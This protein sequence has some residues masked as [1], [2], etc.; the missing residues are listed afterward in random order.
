MTEDADI[1]AEA[2][3]RNKRLFK[4]LASAANAD[5]VAVVGPN[6]PG[7]ARSRGENLWTMSFTCEAWRVDGNKIQKRP[8]TVC[9]KVTG[10]ELEKLQESIQPYQVIRIKARVVI[11]SVFGSPQA[12]L[13]AFVAR[14]SS[15]AEL[16]HVA[17]ELQKPVTLEDS[18]LGTFTLDRRVDWFVGEVVWAGEPISL[19]LSA[20]ADV[21]EALKT[22]HALW[23][24]QKEW[25]RRVRSFAVEQLLP[26]KNDN[27][28]DEDE[29]ELTPD[30]FED[31]MTLESITV[32]ADGSF[33]FWHSDGDLF[34]GHS[35]QISGNLVDGPNHADI[36]G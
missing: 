23:R 31:R 13:E 33:D 28:L 18:L 20:S 12:L 15:D 21:Q 24:N 25:N 4:Q 7:A 9:R 35:I 14:D 3:R 22:A 29:A 34:W 17:E 1:F 8:L 16:N 11:D 27:W 30:Q 36:P 5:V 10:A 6:G 2:E 26:L 32:R 19:N